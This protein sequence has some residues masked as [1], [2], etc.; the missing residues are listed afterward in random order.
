M[1]YLLRATT[2]PAKNHRVL[3][4]QKKV[5][6]DFG[7]QLAVASVTSILKGKTATNFF[8]PHAPPPTHT[9]KTNL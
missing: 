8:S 3:L 5:Y 2:C 6:A 9:H 4:I 1:E 7:G